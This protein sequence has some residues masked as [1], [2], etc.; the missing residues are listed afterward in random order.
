[1]S[2]K[3]LPPNPEPQAVPGGESS[4]PQLGAALQDSVNLRRPK[5]FGR[6]FANPKPP[7]PL[8]P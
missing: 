5:S 1:M 4:V 8:S 7:K 3:P 6:K 2:P